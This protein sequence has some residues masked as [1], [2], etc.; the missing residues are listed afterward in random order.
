MEE[1]EK[2]ICTDCRY[3]FRRKT[4]WDGVRCPYCGK[5]AVERED[6]LNKMIRDEL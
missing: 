4:G 3:G 2:F 6:T 5:N 1:Y